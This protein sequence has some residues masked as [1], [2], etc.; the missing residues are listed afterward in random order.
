MLAVALAVAVFAVLA[1]LASPPGNA[2]LAA[3]IE[4][5]VTRSMGEGRMRIGSLESKLVDGHLRVEELALEDGSGRV[6]I[7]LDSAELQLRPHLAQRTMDVDGLHLVGLYIDLRVDTEGELDV[8]RMFPSSD[9]PVPQLPFDLE[10]RDVQLDDGAF[11]Y[12]TDDQLYL[13]IQAIHLSGSGS[14]SGQLIVLETLTGFG[15]LDEPELGAIAIDGEVAYDLR[16][17]VELSE[18]GLKLDK[19]RGWATVEG[20]VDVE[21]GTVLDLVV[22]GELDGEALVPVTGDVGLHG[23]LGVDARALGPLHELGVTGT[24]AAPEGSAGVDVIVDLEDPEIAYRG[25]ITPD[26]L[27]VGSFVSTIEEPTVLSGEVDLAGRGVIWPDGLEASLEVQLEDSLGWGYRLPGATARLEVQD[28]Q[29]QVTGF[30]YEAWWGE[31]QGSGLLTEVLC[32]LDLEATVWDLQ[33]LEEFEADGLSGAADATGRLRADWSTEEVQVTFDGRLHARKA[34]YEDYVTLGRY[35][36][37]I[38]VEVDGLRVHAE[39]EDAE[40]DEIDASGVTLAYATGSWVADV[41]PAGNVAWTAVA[42]AAAVRVSDLGADAVYVDARGSVGADGS[43]LVDSDMGVL[44]PAY[45]RFD[46]ERGDATLVLVDSAFTI[47]LDLWD[48]SERVGKL[49]G[50][51]DL[52]A[53][54][55]RFEEVS[56]GAESGV[57]WKNNGPVVFTLNQ[58]YDGAEELEAHIQSVAGTVVASG[59][60]GLS[61]PVSARVELD[62]LVVPYLAALYPEELAGWTGNVDAGLEIGGTAEEP[63]IDGWVAVTA[64]SVPGKA[65]GLNAEVDVES[66]DDLVQLGGHID[67]QQGQLLAFRASIPADTRLEAPRL[68][69][70]E[71]VAAEVVL[72]PSATERLRTTFPA[73]TDL[74]PGEASAQLLVAGTLANPS[75]DLRVGARVA[76]GEPR[77]F[78]RLDTTLTIEDGAVALVGTGHDRGVRI[79]DFSGS[80]ATHAHTVT[81]WLFEE[82]PEPDFEAPATW[83]SDLQLTVLP[84]GVEVDLIRRFVEVPE[85]LEGSVTGAIAVSGQPD[86]PKLGGG[87]QLTEGRIDNITVS[88]AV[89][90]LSSE[91]GGWQAFGTFG[92]A[93]GELQELRTI[94]ISGHVPFDLH[95]SSDFDLDAELAREGLDLRLTGDGVPLGVLV[96]ADP[97]IDNAEGILDIE[98]SIVGS[99][100]DPLPELELVLEDGRLEHHDYRVAFEDIDLRVV[101]A[102]TTL[103]VELFR[104]SSRPLDRQRAGFFEELGQRRTLPCVSEFGLAPGETMASGVAQISELSLDAVDLDVCASEAWYSANEE[105]LLQASGDLEMNGFWPQLT[106]TGQAVADRVELT[107][108]EDDFLDDR[109]LRLD[110]FL[111]VVRPSATIASA[112][113]EDPPE[114]WYPWDILVDVDLNRRARLN[115][116]VP[117]MESYSSLGLSTIRLAEGDLDGELQVHMLEDT[118]EVLG[119]VET[120]RG[121]IE[122]VNSDFA[123]QEGTITFGGAEYWN[124]T[125]D[126]RAKRQTGGYGVIEVVV[127]QTV[128]LPTLE[129]RSDRGYTNTDILSILLFGKPT[130]ELGQGAG[131]LLTTQ[132][133][134]IISEQIEG[135]DTSQIFDAFSLETGAQ[136]GVGGVRVG[137]QVGSRGWVEVAWRAADSREDDETPYS[138]TAEWIMTRR[139]QAEF[140]LDEE[141]SADLLTTWRF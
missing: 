45:D 60:I 137:W 1:W 66:L 87:L 94:D 133:T 84:R 22:R 36:G 112:A 8:S 96:L 121:N 56:L 39:G 116:T 125:L 59:R 122:V 63:D 123:L 141:P 6:V 140:S 23:R 79:L 28:G 115:V 73:L 52:D 129:F 104:L 34:G 139:L 138:V 120:I 19:G 70:R 76:A 24:F 124:P 77:E 88:P 14:G 58:D 89:I 103:S 90:G 18:L 13:D 114:F 108:E 67:D 12:G 85:G 41:D 91:E 102:R 130:D 53:R 78:I 7:G 38:H 75:V 86:R 9:G 30:H 93:G 25:K 49:R 113:P 62:G 92:F 43:I 5:E 126:L 69:T 27:D 44:N 99:L 57:V 132:V 2:W 101:A 32:D 11:S 68:I 128:E 21:D 100:A 20:L 61:G 134:G 46:A 3:T 31:V 37:P 106:V 48:G 65:W 95:I 35:R 98:G 55:Y 26:G 10:L 40:I 64:L 107:Y 119:E 47:Q 15:R 131:S 83:V 33:G 50:G 127:G 4:E 17:A 51:G 74:P 109:G 82:G 105:M 110:P 81:A 16:G 29:A 135:I 97:A 118:L 136:G 42:D 111:T 80:A 117:F 54:D 72:Q 71:P